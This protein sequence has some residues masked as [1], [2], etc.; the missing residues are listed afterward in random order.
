MMLQALKQTLRELATPDT[1]RTTR[2]LRPDERRADYERRRGAF[3]AHQA[4]A[5]AE[6]RAQRV[7]EDASRATYDDVVAAEPIPRDRALVVVQ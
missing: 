2:P 6:A 4:I 5:E 3:A 7:M 1:F